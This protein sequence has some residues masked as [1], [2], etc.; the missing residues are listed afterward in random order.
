MLGKKL[1]VDLGSATV[2][3]VTRSEGL[4]F[5]EPAVVARRRAGG[6]PLSVGSAAAD[7]ARGD[8]G[9]RLERPLRGGDLADAEGLA[10][11]IQ[12]VVSRAV[13]RQ[14]IFKPDMVVAVRAGMCSDDRQAILA[15]AVAAGARTV[16]L[17]DVP[18]AAAMGAGLALAETRPALVVDLGA[19]KTDVAVVAGE[20]MVA[21]RSLG[22]G[23][24]DLLDAAAAQVAARHGV[25]LDGDAV[26]EMRRLLAAGPH[27]ERTAEVGGVLLSSLDVAAAVADHLAGLDAALREVLEDTPSPL[28]RAVQDAGATLT[29][30]GAQL[31]GL[32]RHVAAHIGLPAHVA[33]DPQGCTMRGTAMA[34]DH[35]DVLKRSFLY[36]R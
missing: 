23:G 30:G 27:E 11:L 34:V 36:M 15:A 12:H 14:R 17:I 9:L 7:A 13:G 2:R 31:D 10:L 18:L 8:G 35:L 22:R 4:L 6:A 32:A 33:A 26:A 5:S 28:R 16:Y 25:V 1:G 21:A 19:G 3:V 20:G 29:G 24:D